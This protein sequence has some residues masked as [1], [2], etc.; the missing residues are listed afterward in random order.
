MIGKILARHPFHVGRGGQV[1]A[2]LG[3]FFGAY[4]EELNEGYQQTGQQAVIFAQIGG[5]KT[6]MR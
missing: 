1:D 4:R 3:P 2:G 6:R 5:H